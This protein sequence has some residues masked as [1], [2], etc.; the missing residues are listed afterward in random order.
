MWTSWTSM[1]QQGEWTVLRC[2]LVPTKV[3][4]SRG[5]SAYPRKTSNIFKILS[6]A[7]CAL[8]SL[9]DRVYYGQTQACP[10]G[11]WSQESCLTMSVQNQPVLVSPAEFGCVISGLAHCCHHHLLFLQLKEIQQGASVC[12][13]QQQGQAPISRF[14]FSSRLCIWW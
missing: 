2:C 3:N 12:T 9:V 1:V 8:E 14:N 4:G 6:E 7:W 5:Y 13:E 11:I 10:A